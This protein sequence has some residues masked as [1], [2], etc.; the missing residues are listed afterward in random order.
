M[1]R[2]VLPALNEGENLSRL[3]PEIA[4]CLTSA[5]LEF[6]ILIVDDGS[7]DD[8]ADVA[9]EFSNSAPVK[10]LVHR[11]NEGLGK[12]LLT[13]LRAAAE[14]CEETDVILTLDADGSHI[15]AYFTPLVERLFEG[16][17]IAVASRWARSASVLGVP[18]FRMALSKAACVLMSFL[19]PVE[20]LRDYTCGFRAY[21]A[22]IILRG[23][24]E[25]GE[26][27]IEHRDFSC[28]TELL[29]KLVAVGARVA[30]IPFELRYDRKIGKSKLKIL[31][32]LYGYYCLILS[33]WRGHPR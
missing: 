21:R 20:G 9:R 8:T 32:A 23:L 18:A 25:Y 1:L 5:Q 33:M 19:F 31:R 28:G 3:L 27:L 16:F 29:L 13:G 12:A 10:L 6:E 14:S 30:E 24:Q 11:S 17:D 15:P 7:T 4:S 22:E 26:R 2:I